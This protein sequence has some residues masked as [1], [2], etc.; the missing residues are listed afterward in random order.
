MDNSNNKMA[1]VK[2]LKNGNGVQYLL[3]EAYEILGNPML[4]F[5]MNYNL[6]AHIENIVTD[7]QLWNEIITAGNFSSKSIEFF[8]REYFLDAV[9]NNGT[10]TFLN[11]DKLKYNRIVGRVCNS[12]NIKVANIVIVACNKPFEDDDHVV[13]EVFCEKVSK[14]VGKIEFYEK[15]GKI[16]QDIIIKN[17]IDGNISDKRFYS[18]H[19]ANIYEGLRSNLYLA[20][21][22]IA[23]CDPEYTKLMHFKDLFK[24][25]Q[26][27][28][29]YFIYSNYVGIIISSSD[30]KPDVKK[31]LARFKG[32][33]GENNIYVGV[34]R[35]FDNLFELR[36]YYQEAVD[37]LNHGMK[38]NSNYRIFLYDEIM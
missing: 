28:F 23:R 20:V 11:S 38:S 15:Y 36:K 10:I 29:K 24:Q 19:V 26:A 18:G 21:V 22:D 5:D 37:A 32:L 33:L 34:S 3:N 30:A 17:L 27:D 13:F 4:M 12:D 14:E 16:Y 35:C 1:R 2:A 25:T 31:L 6:L 9:A 7:D 8:V